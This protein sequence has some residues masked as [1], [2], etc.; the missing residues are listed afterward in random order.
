MP[1]APASLGNRPFSLSAPI[2]KLLAHRMLA[3]INLSVLGLP[4]AE[5]H[6]P[7]RARQANFERGLSSC[8]NPSVLIS[9]NL[10]RIFT[11]D[12]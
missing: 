10:H 5:F 7:T 3:A 8:H 12:P 9:E 1:T 4:R 11:I 2:S 6:S